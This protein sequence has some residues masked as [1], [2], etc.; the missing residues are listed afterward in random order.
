MQNRL[1]RTLGAWA[2]LDDAEL[3]AALPHARRARRQHSAGP[4]RPRPHAVRPRA[5]DPRRAADP[6]DPRLLRERCCGA[7]RS[8]PASRRSSR[9]S[10]TARP[11]ALREQVLDRLVTAEREAFAAVV[12]LPRRQ[13]SRPAAARDRPPP[14]GLRRRLRPGGPRRCARRRPRADRRSGCCAETVGA[15]DEALIARARC[16]S[17][18]AAAR[19]TARPGM[20]LADALAARDPETRLARLEDA[21]LTGSTAAR[22]S[23]PRATASRPRRCAPPTPASASG[24]T[25]WRAASRPPVRRR[26]G[27]R[28]LRPVDGAQRLRPRLARR[29]GAAPRRRAGCSTS[30]T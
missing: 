9:C 5:R 10:T 20:I 29:L 22:P 27:A 19:T 6:D 1:F 25:R 23:P 15:D 21:L 30:T 13:R 3:R 16:R 28:G 14:R 8:R 4:A 26:I 11:E 18:R 7:S 12:P 2:M 24:S 17:S